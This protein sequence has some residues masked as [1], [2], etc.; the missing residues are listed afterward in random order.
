M[1]GDEATF[2]ARI[3]EK[4]MDEWT[5]VF[6]GTDA[7]VA[8]CGFSTMRSP[9]PTTAPAIR[10][11]TS[12]ASRNRRPSR[13]SRAQR[14]PLPVAPTCRAPAPTRRSAVG[15]AASEIDELARAGAVG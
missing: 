3:E 10:S 2:A 8:R 14:R 9:I 4:T 6:D 12:T 7:C 11:Y 1:A 15:F 13:A 5:A